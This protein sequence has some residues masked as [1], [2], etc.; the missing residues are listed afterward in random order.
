MP[1]TLDG[2]PLEYV[3]L[4]WRGPLAFLRWRA[5]HGGGGHLDWWPD[6]LPAVQRRE[7]RLA[8]ERRP[9]ALQAASMAP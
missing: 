5:S 4:Q 7:L 2:E 6:T 3:Q 9:D 8:V 1:V